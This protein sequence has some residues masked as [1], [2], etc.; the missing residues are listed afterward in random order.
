MAIIRIAS[1]AVNDILRSNQGKRILSNITHLDSNSVENRTSPF[2]RMPPIVIWRIP[3][4]V[5]PTHASHRHSGACLPSSFGA[6]LPSSFGAY[7]PSSFRRMPPIVIPAYTSHR[8]S[9]ACL[10]S[11]FLR[12]SPIVIPTH[13]SHRH[14][15]A[16]RNPVKQS[17]AG[18][19][20]RRHV[21]RLDT[22][23]SPV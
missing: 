8:H 3:P 15:G 5:I 19:K 17:V 20:P 6:Y 2:L 14:S 7:L 22:G 12:I 10:P 16:C 9:D 1:L 21:I 13:A 18:V 23:S 11:S 4:I